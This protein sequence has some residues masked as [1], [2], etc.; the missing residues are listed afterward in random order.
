MKF[1]VIACDLNRICF[2]LQRDLVVLLRVLASV[3][4]A[5]RDLVGGHLDEGM[6]DLE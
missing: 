1:F 2:H 3:G 4:V 5:G 6:K